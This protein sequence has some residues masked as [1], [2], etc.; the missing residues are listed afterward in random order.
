VADKILTCPECGADADELYAESEMRVTYSVRAM[1]AAPDGIETTVAD[2]EYVKGSWRL[3]CL[4]CGAVSEGENWTAGWLVETDQECASSPPPP[5]QLDTSFYV[6]RHRPVCALLN[7]RGVPA[8]EAATGGNNYHV[9][10]DHPSGGFV[11][12]DANEGWWQAGVYVKT[13]DPDWR[14]DPGVMHDSGLPEDAAPALVV[15]WLLEQVCA[16]PGR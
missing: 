11:L 4:R 7:E 2:Q 1:A 16:G 13:D 9:T 12:A 6:A 3:G 14:W 15:A 10:Y 5:R 8:E